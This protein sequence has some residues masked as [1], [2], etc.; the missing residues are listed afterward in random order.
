MRASIV[1]A[2][3]A[4]AALAVP[5]EF[6]HIDAVEN[7]DWDVTEWTA[8][9]ASSG[10]SY[11]FNISGPA[12]TQ[13]PARPAFSAYCSGFGEG[14]PYQECQLLD[15]STTD[16][17]VVAKL[18][19][20][21]P[22]NATSNAVAHIQVSFAYTDLKTSSTSWNFTG[23]GNAGYNQ[24]VSPAMNFTIKPSSITGIA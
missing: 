19:T 24:F 13:N 5:L 4:S 16:R 8:G 12:D 15:S 14:A 7:Y 2:S 3:L 18:L 6:V 9:C 22:S 21:T 20:S 23:T 1:I 17:A 11:N 10:C